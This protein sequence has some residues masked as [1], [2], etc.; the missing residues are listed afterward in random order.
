MKRNNHGIPIVIQL[1][2]ICLVMTVVVVCG[3]HL[4]LSP[5]FEAELLKNE[6]HHSQD[7]VQ[8]VHSLV[9]EYYQRAQ[10]NEFDEKEAQSRALK[11]ISMMRYGENGYFWVNDMNARMLMHPIQAGLNGKDLTAFKDAKGMLLFIEFIRV[12]KKDG[13]GSVDYWWPEPGVNIPVEKTSYVKLFAPWG[14]VIGSG[15]YKTEMQRSIVQLRHNLHIGTVAI[16]ALLVIINIVIALRIARP[17]NR[18]SEFSVK[19]KEDLSL[20]APLEGSMEVQQLAM[21][22]NNTAEQ[23]AVTLVSRDRLDAA[24]KT[25]T[26]MQMQ[27]IHQEKM[28]SIGQLA[29]GVA[30][31]IN[32]PMG[33]ITSNLSTMEKYVARM[34]EY[35][36]AA[37]RLITNSAVAEKEE[38]T[39]L[40]SRLKLDYIINDTLQLIEE[41]LDGATRVKHIVNDLKN[42]SRTDQ[43]EPVYADLNRCLESSLNIACNEIKYVA[44]ID[45]QLG[46]IP[47]ILCHPQQ[48]S[49]VLINLLINAGQ[50]IE[51]HGTITIRTWSEND[52][53]FVAVTDTGKGIPVEVQQ[54]IFEPFFT[55]KDVGKGTG[56]G[57]SIS[58]EIIQKHGG[59]ISVKSDVGKG[60]TFT[61][62]LPLQPVQSGDLT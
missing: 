10:N 37:D 46:V 34:T 12:C 41:S 7:L 29:A 43:A 54:R 22:L 47:E 25:M 3:I 14:W 59:D 21:T 32:N 31:E 28:A 58:Y 52:D 53:V 1:M 30:H 45:L 55:T 2:G 51:G 9:E 38:L 35:L 15:L 40:R 42:L 44:D 57:L 18:L 26:D 56:L 49:Q 13:S 60:T 8:S 16:I 33:F 27:L 62:R 23:L 17:L 6:K 61:V 36:M 50:A 20:R 19:L 48:L 11:R 39:Q 24:L 4:Y 5:L